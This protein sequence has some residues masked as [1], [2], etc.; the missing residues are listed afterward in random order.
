[1]SYPRKMREAPHKARA[2]KARG[3]HFRRFS[4]RVVVVQAA[5]RDHTGPSDTYGKDLQ[6][7]A[8]A[9]FADADVTLPAWWRSIRPGTVAEDHQ[10]CDVVVITDLGDVP[11]QV[12]P[13]RA[14]AIDFIEARRAL[15][16]P[17]IP[18]VVLHP[19]MPQESV[20]SQILHAAE[21]YRR[22][23][24][25]VHNVEVIRIGA[26]GREVRS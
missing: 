15:G 6:D 19:K 3:D 24:L 11:V 7:H 25:D 23:V 12:K 2:A 5:D 21:R 26:R 14:R 10:G 17:E 16:Q 13:S 9:A 22:T 8:I 18:V 1:M 20:R 4:E